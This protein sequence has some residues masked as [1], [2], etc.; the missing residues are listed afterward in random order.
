MQQRAEE[1]LF[2]C[3][4]KVCHILNIGYAAVRAERGNKCTITSPF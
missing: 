4:F 1:G 3:R 2:G